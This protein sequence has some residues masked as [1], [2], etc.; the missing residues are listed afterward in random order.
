MSLFCFRLVSPDTLSLKCAYSNTFHLGNRLYECPKCGL[1]PDRSAQ[2]AEAQELSI[3][4]QTREG[5]LQ[6]DL[7]NIQ[8]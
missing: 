1:S 8:I 2:E 7:F 3:L 5:G 4:G 6:Y